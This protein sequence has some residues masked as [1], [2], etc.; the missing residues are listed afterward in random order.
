MRTAALLAMLALATGAGA[1]AQEMPKPGPEQDLLRQDAGTW[2]AT[3]ELWNAP[4][5]PPEVSKGVSSISMLGGFWQVDDFKATL[6]GQPFEGRGLTGW[7]AAKKSYV[8]VW[9]DSM[10]PGL[11]LSDST[12]DAATKTLTGWAEGPGPDGKPVKSKGVTQWKDADTRVFTMHAPGGPDGQEWLSL[13]IT[14]K[15]RK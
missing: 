1:R 4:G 2:D 13:R 8:G 3:I 14:Y 15:R 9:A 12:Y 6:M 5:T 11:T 10:S 7:D